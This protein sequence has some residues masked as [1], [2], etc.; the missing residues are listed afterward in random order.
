MD[1]STLSNEELQQLANR[2]D[3]QAMVELAERRISGIDTHDSNQRYSDEK[4]Q[5]GSFINQPYIPGQ[6]PPVGTRYDEFNQDRFM[7]TPRQDTGIGQLYE[8]WDAVDDDKAWS[9]ANWGEEP[10]EQKGGISNFWDTIKSFSPVGNLI[11]VIGQ[12]FEYR[13]AYTGIGPYSAQDLDK[14][15]ARGGWYSEPARYMRSQANR[16]SNMLDR[17]RTGKNFSEA[18]LLSIGKQLGTGITSDD[19]SNIVSGAYNISP[20]TFTASSIDQS[21]SGEEGPTSSGSRNQ[22]GFGSSG[23]GRDPRDRMANGGIVSLKR[24]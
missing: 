7:G 5:E 24:D 14:M 17:A 10:M 11:D 19:I 23:M 22:T 21:F 3:F 12:Q 8:G 15:N 2:G 18:N 1:L 13:P 16:Y 4:I 20:N 6:E 9:Y